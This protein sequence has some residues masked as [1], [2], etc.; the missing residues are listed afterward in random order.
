MRV[1]VRAAHR[2]GW[3]EIMSRI[4]GVRIVENSQGFHIMDIVE[5]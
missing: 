5:T 3:E 2:E 1:H 4:M